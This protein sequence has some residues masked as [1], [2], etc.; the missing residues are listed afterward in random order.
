[1]SYTCSI[2]PYLQWSNWV[3]WPHLMVTVQCLVSHRSS[4]H[5]TTMMTS[6]QNVFSN[7][8]FILEN[9]QAFYYW[10]ATVILFHWATL[11]ADLGRNRVTFLHLCGLLLTLASSLIQSC[12][13]CCYSHWC[14]LKHLLS[15]LSVGLTLSVKLA[16]HSCINRKL[17]HI[18]D[19]ETQTWSC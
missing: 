19:E 9:K 8:I 6:T 1:M 11:A 12:P 18:K 3:G 5:F 14:W 7:C 15:R 17:I 2:N 4:N 16:L 13:S 10:R